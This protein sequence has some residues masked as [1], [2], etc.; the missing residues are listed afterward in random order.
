MHK[1]QDVVD[2]IMDRLAEEENKPEN[3]RKSYEAIQ[4]DMTLWHFVNDRR[5]GA[6]G[7]PLDMSDWLVT[8]DFRLLS[9]DARK[10]KEKAAFLSVGIH[11]MTLVQL[12]EFWVPPSQEMDDTLLTSMKLPLMFYNFDPEDEKISLKIIRAISRYE[13]A[14]DLSIKSAE[15]VL[16]D[17]VLRLRISGATT[18]DEEFGIVRDGLVE[19]IREKEREAEEALGRA[20]TYGRAV[21]NLA[22]VLKAKDGVLSA[23]DGALESIAGEL[24]VASDAVIAKDSLIVGLLASKNES[25]AKI[26]AL[27]EADQRRRWLYGK[28]YFPAL[29]LVFLV[30]FV[31]LGPYAQIDWIV[32]IFFVFCFI[33]VSVWLKFVFPSYPKGIGF[34]EIR[35]VGM[36]TRVGGWVWVALAFVIIVVLKDVVSDNWK[37]WLNPIQAGLRIHIW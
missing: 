26:R 27:E 23:K 36:L 13:N 29:C 28:L 3:K 19:L 25:A 5:G 12:L 21:E 10:V 24:Q 37:I 7:S 8:L 32:Q 11:P 4:H 17:E 14:G 20:A 31:L 34:E 35:L 18:P 16:I 2:D 15:S 6:I 9:F 22:D 30:I 33:C 1:R